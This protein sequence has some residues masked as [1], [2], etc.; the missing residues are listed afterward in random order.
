MYGTIARFKLRKDKVRQFFALGKEW[1]DRERKRATGYLGSDVLW[2]DKEDGRG[3]LIV[4]FTSR[5]SYVANASSPEQDRFY[6]RMR[7]CMEVDPE[8]IDGTY[9]RWDDAHAHPPSW[10]AG[11]RG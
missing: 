6:R 7:D 5:E 10:A 8:W 4:R 9:G 11:E 1:D 2:E 3:C